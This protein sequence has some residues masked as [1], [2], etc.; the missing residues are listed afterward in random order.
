MNTSPAQRR[1][2]FFLGAV[3]RLTDPHIYK[4]NNPRS[5]VALCWPTLSALPLPPPL[6]SGSRQRPPLPLRLARRLAS[7]PG[8][9]A[10][11]VDP[12]QV[13]S[14]RGR[15][16]PAT[17]APGDQGGPVA[18]HARRPPFPGAA[19]PSARPGRTAKSRPWAPGL[20]GFGPDLLRHRRLR[21]TAAVS[22]RPAPHPPSAPRPARAFLPWWRLRC[23][24]SPPDSL[25]QRP[26]RQP[27]ARFPPRLT[28]MQPAKCRR[29]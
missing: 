6:D 21:P 13:H 19:S 23:L 15:G 8:A 10:H 11:I 27:A 29:W 3:P 2:N 14:Y 22:H 9:R 24:R 1:Q 25:P 16:T 12:A 28:E 17:V 18:E 4:K 20:S 5:R 26:R 7:A